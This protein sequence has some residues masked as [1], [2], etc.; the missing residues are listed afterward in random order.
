[1]FD[2]AIFKP[3]FDF[4]ILLLCWGVKQ[5]RFSS[6]GIFFI[7]PNTWLEYKKHFRE[8]TVIWVFG[9]CYFG[10]Y[11]PGGWHLWR[12]RRVNCLISLR[13]EH[14]TL[15]IVKHWA[16]GCFSEVHLLECSWSVFSRELAVAIYRW[17]GDRI[18][19]RFLLFTPCRT[20]LWHK[21]WNIWRVFLYRSVQVF[22]DNY[23]LCNIRHFILFHS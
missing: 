13:G 10:E 8:D 18:F 14:Y 4:R 11:R 12:N 5:Y 6:H 2:L 7:T 23:R 21:C 1:M 17:L 16:I 20:H 22:L 3:F 19:G 15:F 9:Q